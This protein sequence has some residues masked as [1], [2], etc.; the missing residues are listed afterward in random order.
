MTPGDGVKGSPMGD[1]RDILK[2]K[3]IAVLVGLSLILGGCGANERSASGNAEKLTTGLLKL[4]APKSEV[5]DQQKS[6]I[7][8]VSMQ[9]LAKA[10][11][12]GGQ[13]PNV[14]LSPMSLELA[15]AMTENGAK[16]DTLAQMESVL[17]GGIPISEM[18][19][20]LYTVSDRL[21]SSEQVDWNIANSVWFKGDGSCKVKNDFLRKAYYWYGAEI[22][23]APFDGTTKDDINDWVSMQTKGMI[24]VI[25]DDIPPNAKMYL[26]NAIA[27]EGEWKSEYNN[28]DIKENREFTNADGSITNVTMLSSD[29]L[30]YFTLGEGIGCLK[31]YKGSEYSFMGLLPPEGTDLDDYIASLADSNADLAD[32]IR[33][34]SCAEVVMQIPEFTDDYDIDMSKTFMDMGMTF[35]F[36][37]FKADFSDMLE[38]VSGTGNICI[39]RILHKTHIEVDR[40]GTKA[41]AATAVEMVVET[42]SA[43][44]EVKKKIHVFLNRPFIYGII[45]N[46]TGLPV[47]LGCVNSL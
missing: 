44:M 47:F 32:A 13:H 33:N 40:N 34:R 24:P 6:A 38:P 27:F 21:A 36:D 41:A 16:G 45:D 29:E 26:I 15:L 14:L 35:P 5:T 43:D 12:Q 28:P 42:A 9:M 25:L 18:N 10:V 7:S 30:Y 20:L 19:S 2:K 31:E 22:W 23:K 11:E 8:V 3:I 17:N 46:A 4:S 1:W 37:E 39:N